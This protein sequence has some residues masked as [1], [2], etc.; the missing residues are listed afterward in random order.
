MKMD[1]AEPQGEMDAGDGITIAVDDSEL[2]LGKNLSM[3]FEFLD[4]VGLFGGVNSPANLDNGSVIR[5]FHETSAIVGWEHRCLPVSVTA[6]N[7]H[8][9]LP[10]MIGRIDKNLCSG[11]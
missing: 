3:I 8:L 10:T 1:H 9:F 7:S 4:R 2:A 5:G 6:K 11:K